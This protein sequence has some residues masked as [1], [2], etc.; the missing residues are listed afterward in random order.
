MDGINNKWAEGLFKECIE[1]ALQTFTKY[2]LVT[3]SMLLP[4]AW[5]PTVF[6]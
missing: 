1:E 6:L 4:G 5:E 2:S 3:L